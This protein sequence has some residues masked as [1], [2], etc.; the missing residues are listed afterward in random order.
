MAYLNPHDGQPARIELT[1]TKRTGSRI[2]LGNEF[3]SDMLAKFRKE[4]TFEDKII[5]FL[6][7]ENFMRCC[8]KIWTR[9]LTGRRMASTISFLTIH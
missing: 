8:N 5:T 3:F 6:F 7:L 4:L 1:I 2:G 9:T